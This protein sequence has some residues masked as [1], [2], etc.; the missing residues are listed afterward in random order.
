MNTNKLKAVSLRTFL[1]VS[2][3]LTGEC[4]V[5]Q[6]LKTFAQRYALGLEASFGIK[7]FN[8]SSDFE[9]I[10][11]LKVIAEGGAVGVSV[12]SGALRAKLRQGYYYSAS[13][14][15][16][17]VD[18]GR[19]AGMLSFYPLELIE[20]NNF[21]VQPFI[22]GGIE[23]NILKMYGFYAPDFPANGLTNYSISEAPYLGKIVSLQAS[24]GA[25]VE[26]SIVKA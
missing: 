22:T 10:N 17:T 15:S 8:L 14:V 25:G 1:I 11:N 24:I 12:G 19:S 2:V 9:A 23:R 18:Y 16:K 5:A 3:L 6:K 20:G 26:F 13:H 4:A 21:S 7:T